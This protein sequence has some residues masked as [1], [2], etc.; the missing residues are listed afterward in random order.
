ME[1]WMPTANRDEKIV[2][3]LFPASLFKRFESWRREQEEI[4]SRADALRA[5][6]ER[7]LAD[8]KRSGAA[9]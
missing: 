5:L 3:A 1:A 8:R 7:A 9:A 2:Q 6:V 4:P